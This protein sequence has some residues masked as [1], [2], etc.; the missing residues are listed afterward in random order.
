MQEITMI[1]GILQK[2]VNDNLLTVRFLA[3]LWNITP[4]AVYNYFNGTEP[5]YGK[6]RT[7]FRRSDKPDVQKEI[8]QDLLSGTGWYAA[9]VEADKDVNGDGDVD[10]DDAMEAALAAMQNHAEFLHK[11]YAASQAGKLSEREHAEARRF[12]ATIIESAVLVDRIIEHV[13]EQQVKRRPARPI[14]A[15]GGQ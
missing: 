10:L 4:Q 15:G 14:V 7:L 6:I 2:L 5:T 1:N 12:A 3:D 9:H 11:F 8:L 13:A